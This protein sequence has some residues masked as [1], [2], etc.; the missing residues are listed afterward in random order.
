LYGANGNQVLGA[1]GIS[2]VD[3][4]PR[5][6]ACIRGGKLQTEYETSS[7]SRI[8]GGMDISAIPLKAAAALF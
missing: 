3:S 1:L 2:A 7:S 8:S 6:S 5:P 4:P